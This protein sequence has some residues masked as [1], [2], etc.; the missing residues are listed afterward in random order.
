MKKLMHFTLIEILVVIAIIGILAGLIFPALLAVQE[1]SRAT[2]TESIL[3]GVSIAIKTFKND[4]SYLPSSKEQIGE[5]SG[6]IDTLRP[7]NDYCEFF[8]ILTYSN[9]NSGSSN[10]TQEVT[11]RNRKAVRYLDI[12]KN[13]FRDSN[14]DTY[15]VR[16]AWDRP[17]MIFLDHNG[18]GQIATDSGIVGESKVIADSVIVSLGSQDEESFSKTDRSAYIVVQ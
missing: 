1:N 9:Y 10:V 11:K 14:P 3:T 6:N 5:W 7:N 4:Y 12:P 2:K 15:S 16:D 13:Y 18:D 17:L 8:D